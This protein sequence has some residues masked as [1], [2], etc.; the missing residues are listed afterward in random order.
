MLSDSDSV[1]AAQRRMTEAAIALSKL[2]PE[3]AQAKQIREFNSDRL[4]RMFSVLVTEQY[5]KGIKST[6]EAEHRARASAAYGSQLNDLSAQLESAQRTIEKHAAL[7]VQYE[8]ARSIL[9][10][11]KAKMAL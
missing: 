3:V 6:S 4:K 8:A 2:A 9:S 1:G 7:M 11:E 10:M 5:D